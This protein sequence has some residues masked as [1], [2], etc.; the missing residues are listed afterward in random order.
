MMF[1]RKNCFPKSYNF[2]YLTNL[3]LLA[4][5]FLLTDSLFGVSINHQRSALAN[6]VGWIQVDKLGESNIS[7]SLR[8]INSNNHFFL[9]IAGLSKLMELPISR[10]SGGSM[11]ISV[12][13]PSNL[14]TFTAGNPFVWIDDKL[15]QLI[16]P[17]KYTIENDKSFLLWISLEAFLE[18]A[19]KY[20]PGEVLYDHSKPR[21]LITTPQFDLHGLKIRNY[22]RESHLIFTSRRLLE[23]K[24]EKLIKN[25]PVVSLLFTGA[26]ADIATLNAVNTSG[27]IKR[28]NAVKENNTL[29][30][31]VWYDSLAKFSEIEIESDPPIYI[32]KFASN[33]TLAGVSDPDVISRLDRERNRWKYDIV[34][35][36]PGHGGKD[37]G[38]I[39]PAG[40]KEKDITLDVGLRLRKELEKRGVKVVMTR[41]KDVFIP[42]DERGKIANRIDGK[43]FISLHCNAAKDQRARGMETYFLSQ[44][45]TDR[46]MQVAMRENAVIKYEENS[47]KYKELTEENFILLNMAQTGF[48]QESQDLADIVQQYVPSKIGLKNRGVDQAGFYVL[49]GASM[50]AILFEMGFISNRE[51]EKK[52]RDKDFRAKL[53]VEIAES[54]VKFLKQ[55]KS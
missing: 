14:I 16:V 42:L 43:L 13:F 5:L 1:L 44:T 27:L 31:D 7:D 9:D 46:A 2:I 51:E 37:P 55:R 24:A 19:R 54:V 34:V 36:D 22:A 6:N 26:T 20:Y 45:K 50:P 8:I 12:D 29:R 11:R 3:T 18:I 25:S 49:V 10:A 47:A 28:L 48:I 40:T 39:G 23:C 30:I 15:L 35:I 32:A 38:A 53:A 52:L 33:Q 4:L 17:I 41:E 21:L